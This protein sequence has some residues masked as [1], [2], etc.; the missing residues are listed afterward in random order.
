M[1]QLSYGTRGAYGHSA[2]KSPRSSIT[3]R[4]CLISCEMMSQK[5]QRSFCWK[6]SRA[7]TQL[8]QNA[9]GHECGRGQL[10]SRVLE[11]LSRADAVILK[12]ADVLEAS[13]AF[14][15]L[16]ALRCQQKKLFNLGITCLP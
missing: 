15:I 4:S 16:N 12:D 1:I 6:Y 11:L 2:M 8:V 10:R 3:R 9:A 13:I 14:Q 5:T 7:G